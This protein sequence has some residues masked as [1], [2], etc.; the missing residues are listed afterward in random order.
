MRL[1]AIETSETVGSVAALESGNLLTEHDL[2]RHQGS[3]QTLAPAIRDLLAE[4]GWRPGQIEVVAVTV[5]PGSF[6]GL[7]V[8]VTTAKVLAYSA[9]AHVLGVDTLEAIAAGCP[10]QV[11]HLAVVMDAQRGQVVAGTFRRAQD[12][13]FSASEPWQLA[14]LEAWLAALPTGIWVAGPV[15]QRLTQGLPEG[16]RTLDPQYW[17]PKA[18]WVGRLAA[19]RYASGQHDDVW[20]LVPRYYRPS[21]A[22]ERWEQKHRKDER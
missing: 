9:G 12:G 15:L 1:L 18:S 2:P 4:V 22:E 5:G 7:R 19:R 20:S 8:G 17:L 3:A 11:D 16:L 13:W 21:A 10:T 6:T 14:D